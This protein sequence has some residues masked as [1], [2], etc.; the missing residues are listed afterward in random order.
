VTEGPPVTESGAWR[1][2]NWVDYD[3]DGYLDLIVTRGLAGGQDNV[4]FHNDGPPTFT[5]TRMSGLVI[6]QDHEPSDGST[7]ADYDNDGYLD[8]FVANWYN[9]NNLM[10]HNNANGSFTRIT[11]GLQVNNGGYS[12]TASWGDYNNDGLVDL[13]VANSAGSRINF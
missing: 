1:S 4:L 12:E 2:V 3:R 7:W 10:Y 9:R 6:S 13:Y 5:F 8:C 11:S